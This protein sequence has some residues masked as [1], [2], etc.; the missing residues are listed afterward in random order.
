MWWPFH[1]RNDTSWNNELYRKQQFSYTSIFFRKK[2]LF[3]LSSQRL[4]IVYKSCTKIIFI[5]PHYE[6]SASTYA[7]TLKW[8]FPLNFF[9]KNSGLRVV[10]EH[11]ENTYEKTLKRSSFAHKKCLFLARRKHS[12]DWSHCFVADN[13]NLLT[14]IPGYN[15]LGLKVIFKKW[16]DPAWPSPSWT[17]LGSA[18]WSRSS[19]A[20][21]GR[22]IM[23][24]RTAL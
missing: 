20:A 21:L 5:R 14:Q 15:P 23:F 18:G 11:V 16:P 24:V 19:E 3:Q 9:Y 13:G 12:W 8:K 7:A 4:N 17:G 10:S 1:Y 22:S 6:V 2:I